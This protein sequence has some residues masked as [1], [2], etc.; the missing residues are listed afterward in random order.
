VSKKH[1]ITLPTN[2]KH[3]LFLVY[4]NVARPLILPYERL[5]DEKGKKLDNIVVTNETCRLRSFKYAMDG[6]VYQS[7]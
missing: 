1:T 3:I 4:G 6:A 7:N 2:L 5:D